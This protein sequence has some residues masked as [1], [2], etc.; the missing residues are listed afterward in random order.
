MHDISP[1]YCSGSADSDVQIWW[2]M[3][4]CLWPKLCQ[5]RAV[6]MTIQLV[7]KGQLRSL[8]N[9]SIKGNWDHY[10]TY[11]IVRSYCPSPL[12]PLWCCPCLLKTKVGSSLKLRLFLTS[13]HISNGIILREIRQDRLCL[14]MVLKWYHN[15]YFFNFAIHKLH[16]SAISN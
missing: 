10:T 4:V 1:Q 9:W 3:C 12:Y 8:F 6:E 13:L 16:W 7:S 11:S 2:F 5:Q 15:F 14:T